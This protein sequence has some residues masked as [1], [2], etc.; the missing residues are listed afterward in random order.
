MK[1]ILGLI[2]YHFLVLLREPIT[3]F[4]SVSL[5]FVLLFLQ[6]SQMRETMTDGTPVMDMAIPTFII[7]TIMTL[8]ILD[9]GYS[10]AHARQTKF[11]R[12]LRMTP[13][14]TLDYILS[15]VVGRVVVLLVFVLALF[16]FSTSLFDVSLGGRNWLMISG[17]LLLIFAMFYFLGIF[18]ANIMKTGK[19]SQSICNAVYFILL[20]VGGIFV[21]IEAM[22]AVARPVAENLPTARAIE[23]LSAAWSGNDILTGGHLIIVSIVTVVFAILSIKFFKYE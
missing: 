18:F 12:R 4:L 9:L 22:P 2:K 7:M 23:L 3:M 8:C 5:P 1:K 17:I 19:A 14:S 21:G 13:M 10:H 11:L 16:A 6:Q 20:F 15:G